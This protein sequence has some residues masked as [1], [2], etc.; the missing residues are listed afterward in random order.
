MSEQ[1]ERVRRR[2]KKRANHEGAVYQTDEG[3]WRA[4]VR[5]PNGKTKYF[6]APTQAAVLAKKKDFELQLAQGLESLD[7]EQPVKVFLER[8]LADVQKN[9]VRTSTYESYEQVLRKR[10]YPRIGNLKLSKVTGQHLQALYSELQKEGY[11][12]ASVVRTHSILHKAFKQAL[13]WRIIV[14]NPADEVSRPRIP[15]HEMKTLDV[16]QVRALV[17]AAS[18]QLWRALFALAGTHG[19]RR[20]E[21][22]A[23]RWRDIDLVEGSLSVVRT[24]HHPKGGGYEFSEPKTKNGRRKIRLAQHVLKELRAHRT[25]QLEH[26]LAAGEFWVDEDLV[27]ANE[28]GRPLGED[29]VTENF[30]RA[31]ERAELPRIRFHDLRHTAAT[32]MMSLGVHAK[33]VQ[34][35]LGHGN[36][37]ITLDI[38]SHV[39]PD[40]QQ[41]AV[42][43]LNQR[44]GS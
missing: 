12:P 24:L 37:G 44:Y 41:D 13:M 28:F 2:G 30:H 39:T 31:L 34:E 7:A 27:F 15:R 21:A 11:S 20:G 16:E 18:S 22:L 3:R 32:V 9:A 42:E 26:R 5:L 6:Q 10:V 33:M 17:E 1:T 29:K 19:L 36:V 4:E 43:K 14:R 23:T 8:W 38:Y 35:T 40:M 25:E